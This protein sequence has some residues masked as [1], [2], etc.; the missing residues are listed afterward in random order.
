MTLFPTRRNLRRCLLINFIRC[1]F[2]QINRHKQH[3]ASNYP[4]HNNMI[5]RQSRRVNRTHHTNIIISTQTHS[6]CISLHRPKK[7]GKEQQIT[8]TKNHNQNSGEQTKVERQTNNLRRNIAGYRRGILPN[9]LHA[10]K[11]K[12]DPPQC[13]RQNGAPAGAGDSRE[14]I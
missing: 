2:S 5:V 14:R 9:T 10:G 3:R 11:R 4:N 1:A 13:R 7:K 6:T 12:E 8:R